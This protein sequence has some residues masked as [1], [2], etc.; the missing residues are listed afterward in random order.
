MKTTPEVCKMKNIEYQFQ[1]PIE[2][3]SKRTNSCLYPLTLLNLCRHSMTVTGGSSRK[4]EKNLTRPF[5]IAFGYIDDVHLCQ[6]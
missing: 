5:N 6:K 1:N 4:N 3:R 2:N